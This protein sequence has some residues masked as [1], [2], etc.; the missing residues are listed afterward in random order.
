MATA[1]IDA[2]S[3][4]AKRF[5]LGTPLKERPDREHGSAGALTRVGC[6]IGTRRDRAS[7]ASRRR[8]IVRASGKS[9]VITKRVTTNFLDDR[10][11]PFVGRAG[12]PLPRDRAVPLDGAM[13]DDDLPH[14]DS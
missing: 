10:H 8:D 11:A 14:D 3:G 9:P 5:I 13:G 4:N 7:M 1:A 12:F 2:A 6:G